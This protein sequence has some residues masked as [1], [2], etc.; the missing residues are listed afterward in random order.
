MMLPRL[1]TR[2]G[3]L[4]VKGRQKSHIHPRKASDSGRPQAESAAMFG[5]RDRGADEVD[6]TLTAASR[7]A[8]PMASP[9]T[10]PLPAYRLRLADRL[11]VLGE[12]EVTRPPVISLDGAMITFVATGIWNGATT[13]QHRMMRVPVDQGFEVIRDGAAQAFVRRARVAQSSGARILVLDLAHPD[14]DIVASAG[15]KYATVCTVHHTLNF[16]AG[17]STAEA[18]STH[19]EEWC[20]PCAATAT[21]LALDR[22]HGAG[23]T[24]RRASA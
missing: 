15:E 11:P 5:S 20:P 12:V 21:G 2:G 22:V 3:S 23:A 14:S 16:H 4:R 8:N 9:I 17:I 24:L 1:H 18:Q 13:T 10:V 7:K 19:P 6:R